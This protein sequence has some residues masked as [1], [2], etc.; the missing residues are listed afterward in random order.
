MYDSDDGTVRD[1]QETLPLTPPPTPN[2]NQEIPHH[3][4]NRVDV[5]PQRADP[6]LAA[7]DPQHLSPSHL[8]NDDA[9]SSSIDTA[10]KMPRALA[11]IQNFNDP[12]EKEQEQSLNNHHESVLHTVASRSPR[13]D[14]AKQQELHKWLDMDTYEE[15]EDHGQ[16]YIS[17][18]WVCTEKLKG[19]EVVL[20]ARLVARGFEENTYELRKDSP[21]C[22]KESLRSFLCILAAKQWRLSS[23]DIK[24]A[25]LQGIPINR[26]LYIKPPKEANTN[27]LWRLK[28]CPYGLADAGRHWY[29]KVQHELKALGGKQLPLDQSVYVWQDADGQTEGMMVVHVDDFI[30]GGTDRF[31]NTVVAQ[32]RK[33]FTIGSEESQVMRYIGVQ[34]TQSST[35][36]TLST[37]TYCEDLQEI[38]TTHLGPDRSRPLV[39]GEVTKL[40]Q[41]SGQ[42]NWVVQQSRPDCAFESCI[43][44]NS[45][46]NA[47]VQDIHQANKAIRKAHGQSV[48][49]PFSRDFDLSTCRIVAFSDASFANLRGCGSQGAYMIF[50]CDGRGIWCLISW[51]SRRIVRVVNSTLAAECLAAVEAAQASIALSH[52]ISGMLGCHKIPISVLCDNRSVV[53]AAHSSTAVKDKRLQIDISI[54]RD[55]IDQ[56]EIHELRWVETG[57]QVANSLTKNGCSTQYLLDIIRLKKRFDSQTGAFV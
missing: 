27:K 43:V 16:D 20:K 51:Q 8:K 18:R 11:R 22:Q 14:Q 44:A 40:R 23:I 30:Y 46:K 17:A 10:V 55:I 24:S 37:N 45:T 13:F 32:F 49:L 1:H 19:E 39:P 53:D 26:T 34:I 7:P 57:L 6:A 12:G 9:G 48:E 21:T 25:Y 28:K 56:R 50:L 41:I 3:E 38:D 5:S 36:I 29:I 33:S 52:H 35:G 47:V 31:L 4:L 2:H 42:L 54:L 15:V